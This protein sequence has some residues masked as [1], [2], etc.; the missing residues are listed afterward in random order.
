M[1]IRSGGGMR[2]P[3]EMGLSVF[4][5]EIDGIVYYGVYDIKF[6]DDGNS[7]WIRISDF[8]YREKTAIGSRGIEFRARFSH[9]KAIEITRFVSKCFSEP[10]LIRSWYPSLLGDPMTRPVEF[11]EDWIFSTKE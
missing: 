9:E 7:F 8:G 2:G 3:D 5:L 11:S 1:M 10:S 4:I 6:E